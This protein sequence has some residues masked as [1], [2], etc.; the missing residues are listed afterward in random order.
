MP[1]DTPKQCSGG[2]QDKKRG[3]E[4]VSDLLPKIRRETPIQRQQL[5]V[6]LVNS[7]SLQNKVYDLA[8]IA[9]LE[10]FDIIGVTESWINTEK[11]DFL[12]EYSI[13]GYTLFSFEW[14]ERAGGGVLLY[15]KPHLHPQVITKPQ[16]SNIDV[17]YVQILSGSEKLILVLVYRPPAQNPNVDNKLYEQILDIC[18]HND[19]IIFG[20]FNLPVTVWGGTLNSHSGH[21]LYS[22][23]LE[24][25][26]YQHIYE[27]TRGE[28]IL[29]IVL[30]TND[31]QISNVDIGPKFS[32]SDH[33]NVLFSIECN[34]GM[35]N[36]SYE[37]VPDFLRADFDKL[38]TILENTDWSQIYGTQDV[39]QAWNMFTDILTNAIAECIPM[40][41]RRPANDN[42]HKWWNIGIRNILLA[43][44]RAYR[45]YKSTQSQADKLD[46]TRIC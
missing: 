5:K 3:T 38:R 37:K 13:Q 1:R 7:H 42:K 18:N 9:F 25:S 6:C 26:L 31:N 36:D 20:D 14:S 30:S 15:V 24:S 45:R 40:S 27:P 33:R 21:E 39:E 10:N 19:V 12:A 22:N 43:K 4:G 46:Y 16:I 17:K 35:Y 34:I 23:I 44:K 11:R 2:S 41:D 28:N 32:T 8:V 29:D